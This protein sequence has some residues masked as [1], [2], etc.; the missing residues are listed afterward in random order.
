MALA[1][2]GAL[3]VEKGSPKKESD[4]VDSHWLEW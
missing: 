3:K 4:E 2:R 1:T